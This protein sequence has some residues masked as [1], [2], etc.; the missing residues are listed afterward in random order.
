MSGL[1]LESVAYAHRDRHVQVFVCK[2][3]CYL[4]CLRFVMIRLEIIENS[5]RV[6]SRLLLVIA[7][8]FFYHSV[9]RLS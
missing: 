3:I 1:A 2:T 9:P 7:F 8:P 5:V 6:C 4:L